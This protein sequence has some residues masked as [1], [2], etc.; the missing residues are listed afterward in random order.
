MHASTSTS[1]AGGG[2][3]HWVLGSFSATFAMNSP[4]TQALLNPQT[5]SNQE[6]RTVLQ[7]DFDNVWSRAAVVALASGAEVET[8]K[9]MVEAFTT[10]CNHGRWRGT[11]HED[12]PRNRSRVNDQPRA[13]A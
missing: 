10:G 8:A 6:L 11:T 1:G 12:A 13:Q 9:G 7:A 2:C 5:N 3:G 4:S